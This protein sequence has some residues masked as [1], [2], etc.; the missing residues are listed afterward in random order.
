MIA[1]D[2]RGCARSER[3]R[4][5]ERTSV[6][7]H[8]DDAAALLGAL[9]AGPA[10][11]V[12]RS[13]GGTVALDL[14]VR[15]PGR[16]RAIVLLEPDA[17]RELAPAAAAWVDALVDRLRA[18]AVADGDD[19]V[20]E[21]LISEVAGSDAWSAFPDDLRRAIAGNGP[22]ILAELAGEWWLDAD[23]AR[24]LGDRAAAPWW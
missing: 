2:R 8:S 14:A 11:V 6:A 10:I 5:Y 16:V 7:E 3:P 24:A 12:G 21:A 18:V 17:P 20:P 19:A 15:H 1:Y 13:Y 4:R 22:A 23:A 9:A